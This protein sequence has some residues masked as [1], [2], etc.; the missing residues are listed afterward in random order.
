ME[1]NKLDNPAWY[2]LNATHKD[3]VVEYGKIKFYHPDYS[4]FGG[5][6]ND[7][8]TESGIAKYASLSDSFFVFRN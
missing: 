6:M 4:P 5:A 1:M 3:F 7:K 8:E 2:C